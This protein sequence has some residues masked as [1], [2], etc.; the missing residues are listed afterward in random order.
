MLVRDK[1]EKEFQLLY[2]SANGGIG[3]GLTPFSPLKIGIL[4][5]KYNDGIPDDSR[6][7]TTKDGYIDMLKK[8]FGND[9][10]KRQ[11][12]IVRNL[13]PVAEK[14]G[15]TQAALALA[16]VIKNPHVSSAITGASKVEQVHKSLDALTVLPKLT[17]E[18]MDEIDSILG[19]KPEAMTMRF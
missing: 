7:A 4:T 6:L 14:L 15:C 8:E 18:V 13:K 9:D 19:N 12:E 5:G 17:T 16:W 10:W 1:V 2:S 3:L 11:L